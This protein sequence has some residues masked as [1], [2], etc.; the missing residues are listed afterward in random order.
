MG[1]GVSMLPGAPEASSSGTR[2]SCPGTAAEEV[3]QSAVLEAEAPEA[4]AGPREEEPD[5][6][7]QHGAPEAVS[8]GA[9]PVAHRAGHHV[10]HLGR[11]RVDF[12]ALQKRRGYLSCSSGVIRPL[13]HRKYITV[14][15]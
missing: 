6:S 3:M 1:T 12:A 10:Q 7:P 2:D 9:S 15:E 14:D 11:F 13:K 8:L 5:G 4:S